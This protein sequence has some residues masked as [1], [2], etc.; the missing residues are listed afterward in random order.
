MPD[1]LWL[2]LAVLAGVAIGVV[3]AGELRLWRRMHEPVL[4]L[5]DADVFVLD[6][7]DPR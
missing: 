5:V 4:D 7:D 3:V 6:W 1:A 2:V